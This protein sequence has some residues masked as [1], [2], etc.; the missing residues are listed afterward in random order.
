MRRWKPQP[1]FGPWVAAVLLILVGIGSAAVALRLGQAFRGPPESWSINLALYGWLLALISLL[2]VGGVIAYRLISALTLVYDLDR[3]GLYIVWL[4]NRATVP[5]DQIVGID[6]GAPGASAPL[7]DG[8][9]LYRGQTHTSDRRP[10]YM[11][12]TRPLA[13]CLV[14]NTPQAAY[15][16]SP[17]NQDTFVQELEQRRSLGVAK[18]VAPTV[19]SG[20]AFAYAFWRDNIVRWAV[21]LAI[22]VNLLV[23]ALL[24]ARYPGLPSSLPMQFDLTGEAVGFRARYQVFFLPLAA[25]A[26][27]LLNIAVGLRLYPHQ[28]ISARLL[29]VASFVVQL[30][31]AVASLTI[32]SGRV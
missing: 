31:F 32:I 17:R 28:Q 8:L 7:L 19:Q 10:L 24:A 13:R 16:V 21:F 18:V 15:A 12:A 29:Q 5:L 14:I 1:A 26:L 3:N 23:L 9:G 20:P 11:F 27:C 2:G 22:M 25:L 6:I 30:L 4:G